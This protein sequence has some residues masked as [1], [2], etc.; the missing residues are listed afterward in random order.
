[1][2]K[3]NLNYVGLTGRV[4]NAAL[5]ARDTCSTPVR[6]RASRCDETLNCASH[7]HVTDRLEFSVFTHVRLS[8]CVRDT[9]VFIGEIK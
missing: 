1:M 9:H 5:I 2:S 6:A 7:H 8:V 3:D 4:V